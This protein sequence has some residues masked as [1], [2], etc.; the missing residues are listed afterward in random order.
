[1]YFSSVIEKKQRSDVCM[2]LVENH[3]LLSRNSLYVRKYFGKE[4]MKAA[5]EIVTGL[6][7]EFE[8]ILRKVRTVNQ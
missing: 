5:V 2:E 1:M 7:K 8:N 6:K 4:E 3:L